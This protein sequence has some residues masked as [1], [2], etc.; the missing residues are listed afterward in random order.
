MSTEQANRDI[1]NKPMPFLVV[2]GLPIIAIT[3]TN[4]LSGTVSLAA[5]TVI[6]SGSLAWMGIGCLINAARCGRLHCKVSGPI[7]L[8][9]SIGILIDSF[10]LWTPSGQF[11]ME[12]FWV[13]VL[14]ALSTYILEWVWGPYGNGR[15]VK[16]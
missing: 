5:I 11:L 14:M 4:F 7:F 12:I 13:T 8:V 1:A 2:W 10:G 16:S 15:Q 6:I 3:A 9:G